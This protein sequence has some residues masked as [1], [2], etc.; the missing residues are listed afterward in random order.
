MAIIIERITKAGKVL[1]RHKFSAN[2]VVIGRSYHSDVIVSDEHVCPEHVRIVRDEQDQV[3]LHDLNTVNGTLYNRQQIRSPL[4]LP[5][6]QRFQI[7]RAWFRVLQA[8]HPVAPTKML[9]KVDKVLARLSHPSVAVLAVVLFLVLKVQQ[10][11]WATQ[12]ETTYAKVLGGGIASVMLLLLWPLLLLV[13]SRFSKNE[14]RFWQQVSIA[15]LGFIVVMANDVLFSWLGFNG[16]LPGATE[17]FEVLSVGVLLSGMLWLHLATGFNFSNLGRTVCSIGLVTLLLGSIYSVTHLADD[18]SANARYDSTLFAPSG[19]WQQGR[20]L[21]AIMADWQQQLAVAQDVSLPS[22]ATS[23]TDG[24][25][26]SNAAGQS[27][28]ADQSNAI[29]QN[30]GAQ[31]NA[32]AA[33]PD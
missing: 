30:D 4:K 1:E 12:V 23:Q 2:S 11:F 28:A 15:Y 32:E 31:P 21:D 27:N 19:Q 5:S 17:L 14:P 26:P 7:G 3:W 9:T 8:D 25:E 10:D 13:C 6:G 20:S 18:F 29:G 24:V 16:L 22:E 33:K